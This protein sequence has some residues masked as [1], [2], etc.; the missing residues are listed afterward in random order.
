MGA[1]TAYVL[2][3][4]S[5]QLNAVVLAECPLLAGGRRW[6]VHL[7]LC[8]GRRQASVAGTIAREQ[9]GVWVMRK[10]HW[11]KD[12]CLA[13]SPRHEVAFEVTRGKVTIFQT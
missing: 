2:R 3:R 8:L 5:W 13:D 1:D 10:A 6:Q 9:W 7:P 4:A 11:L 12:A